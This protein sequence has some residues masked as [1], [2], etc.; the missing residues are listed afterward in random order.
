MIEKRVNGLCMYKFP[1]LA[2]VSGIRHGIFARTGGYS[3]GTY[4][5]LNVAFSVGDSPAAVR[6]NRQAIG[7]AMGDTDLVFIN[8]VHGTRIVVLDRSCDGPREKQPATSQGDAVI[9]DIPGKSLV[10]QSADCQP[11]LLYD[12]IRHAVGN[13]H[14]GWRGS[15]RNIIGQTVAAMTAT[16]STRPRDLLAGIGPSLGPCCAEFIHYRREIPEPLWS[17]KTRKHHFDFWAM[18]REQLMVAGVPKENI[19]TSGLCTR[20]R[21]DLFFSYRGEKTTGRFAAVIA[22]V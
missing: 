12:P 5:S 3:Q 19:I 10:I 7:R 13:I 16:F 20:C 21:T 2:G 14:S 1:N 22:I 17:Y 15:V 11:I 8:Q 9:T 18:S 4:N 6:K